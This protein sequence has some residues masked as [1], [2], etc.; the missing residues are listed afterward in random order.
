ML[1]HSPGLHS[2]PDDRRWCWTEIWGPSLHFLSHTIP[3][4]IE[5]TFLRLIGVRVKCF[6]IVPLAFRT[7]GS[8]LPCWSGLA[9][10][11]LQLPG[12]SRLI[13][14]G[15]VA[16]PVSAGDLSLILPSFAREP[17]DLDDNIH[18]N[19]LLSPLFLTR[20]NSNTACSYKNK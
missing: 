4:N 11:C 2:N 16:N 6:L 3:S 8:L 13:S 15:V 7:Q 5:K 17:H 1:L 10:G 18:L 20:S 14:G 19:R 12:H 9:R